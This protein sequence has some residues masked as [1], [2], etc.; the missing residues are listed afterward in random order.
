M[1]VDQPVNQNSADIF[2]NLGLSL[3][4]SRVGLGVTFY[5][6]HILLNISAVLTHMVDVSQG[7]SVYFGNVLGNVTLNTLLVHCLLGAEANLW[8]LIL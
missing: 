3:H 1:N 8:Q 4:V 5:I 2:I 6:L 7:G